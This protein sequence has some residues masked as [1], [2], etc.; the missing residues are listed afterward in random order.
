MSARSLCAMLITRSLKDLTMEEEEIVVDYLSDLGIDVDAD[1]T[2]KTMC[3]ELLEKLMQKELGKKVPLTAYANQIKAAEVE[4]AKLVALK[5]KE[6]GRDRIKRDLEAKVKVLPGCIDAKLG[7][8]SSNVVP[9][10]LIIDREL[11]LY[12]VDDSTGENL[13]RYSAVMSISKSLYERI[14]NQ[15]DDPVIQIVTFDGRVAYARIATSHPKEDS[16]IYVS[17]LVA[18]ILGV[19]DKQ[20]FKALLKLCN[21][22]PAISR[23]KFSYYGSQVDL[24]RILPLLIERLPS[25]INAYSYLSLGMVIHATLEGDRVRVDELYDAEDRPIFA[26]IL[27][28]GINELPFEIVAEE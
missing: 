19:G 12:R 21:S 27:P 24:D 6:I 17:P 18:T 16:V 2:P 15:I 23:I 10:D 3:V 5:R 20:R 11:G 14:F 13:S 9:Y 26:G 8:L 28:F 4:N 1:A 22:L 25:L 7:I